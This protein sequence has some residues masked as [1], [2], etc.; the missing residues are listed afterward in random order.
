MFGSTN[1]GI[2]G[3]N[4]V[5][6]HRLKVPAGAVAACYLS[7]PIRLLRCY[8]YE[9]AMVCCAKLY[10]ALWRSPPIFV[11]PWVE[12]GIVGKLVLPALLFAFCFHTCLSTLQ[13]TRQ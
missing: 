6:Q 5:T 11:K 9:C 8:R 13:Y 4:S 2:V 1:T 12:R 3:L 10:C 7:Q